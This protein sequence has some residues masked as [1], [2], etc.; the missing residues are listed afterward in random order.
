M[1]EYIDLDNSV[2]LDQVI[3]S[4]DFYSKL[5]FMV[6]KVKQKAAKN[7]EHY[8]EKQIA[9]AIRKKYEEPS[10]YTRETAKTAVL[11]NVK[12]SEVYGS[13]W[14]YDFLSLVETVKIDV[15][16]KVDN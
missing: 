2:G 7:Y 12:Y 1:Q 5:K 15:D 10:Q 13:N 4:R 8:R 11:D 3:T 6:F 9:A 16:I 14:P